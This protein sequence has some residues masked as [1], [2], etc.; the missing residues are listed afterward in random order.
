MTR[1]TIL[2]EIDSTNPRYLIVSAGAQELSVVPLTVGVSVFVG[3][4]ADCRIQLPGESSQEIQCVLLLKEDNVLTIR[5]QNT[6]TTFL[7]DHCLSDEAQVRSGDVVTVGRCRLTPVLD[8]EFHDGFAIELLSESGVYSA[9]GVAGN[10][11]LEIDSLDG[12]D[13]AFSFDA[14]YGLSRRRPKRAETSFKYDFDADLKEDLVEDNRLAYK[15]PASGAS[16]DSNSMSAEIEQLR[17]EIADRDAQILALSQQVAAADQ[18]STVD[19]SDT[20]KLVSRLEEL[21]EELKLSDDRVQGL[22]ELLRVSEHATMAEREERLQINT[23]LN[24]IEKRIGQRE[25]E[26]EAEI[27]SLTRQVQNAKQN[28][29]VIQTQFESMSVVSSGSEEKND[30]LAALNEQVQ[31]LRSSLQ[32]ANEKN[33]EL[34]KR[35]V[36]SEQNIDFR[37]KMHEAQDELAKFRL[38]ASKERAEMARR[39][40]EL[41]SIRDELEIRANKPARNFDESVT[42]MRAL[43]EHLKDIHAEE[44]AAKAKEKS[45]S[46]GGRIASLL[47]RLR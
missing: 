20:L 33:R 12:T 10:T 39:H 43:R 24:E 41:E 3:S 14:G 15:S 34:I 42:R 21:L 35:S 23:W 38:E 47:T 27:D 11:D 37:T 1:N 30:A 31:E 6:G 44:M 32:E 19:E 7:N 46:L 17:F 28:A 2:S 5:D 29:D 40:A 16:L 36:V 22:E 45:N 9:D 18:S 8:V 26:L 13:S 25:A 4:G